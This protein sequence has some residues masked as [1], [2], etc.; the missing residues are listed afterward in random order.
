MDIGAPYNRVAVIRYA[1]GTEKDI[2][3]VH[4]QMEIF[5]RYSFARTRKEIDVQKEKS[6]RARSHHAH[7]HTHRETHAHPFQS[8]HNDKT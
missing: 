3:V 4:C 1:S 7:K 2:T 5:T 8:G 6:A